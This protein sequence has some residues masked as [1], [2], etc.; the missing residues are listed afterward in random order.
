MIRVGIAGL[1]FM[2]M[3]HYL[4]YQRKRGVR[5]AAICE[6]SARRLAGDWRDI[7]GNFEPAGKRMDLSGVS[8]YKSLPE[9]LADKTL[10]LIDVTLPPALHADVAIQALQ[11]GKHVFCEKPMSLN[12]RDCQR[13]LD[14]AKRAGKLLL[15]GH[16]LPFFPEY[17]WALNVA[18]S[19]KYGRLLGGSFKRVISDPTWLSDYW[20]ADRVGGPMLD[21]HVHDAHFIRLLAGMPK[22]VASCGRLRNE[23]AEF[24][25]T[26]FDYGP[27]GP[28]VQAT[29]GTIGQ[30]SRPFNHGF[31]IHLERA[32]L[33]FEF[34]VLGGE[35][36]YLCPPTVITGSRQ[37][38]SPA[39][40]GGDPLDA[41]AN[42]IGE[43]LHCLRN[44]SHSEILDAQIA[45]D[46][47][48]LCQKQTESLRKGRSVRIH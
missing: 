38:R 22:S 20:Q 32:T 44:G 1:G 13:M 17:R 15:I 24:W 19:G 37:V 14:A 28:V 47:I 33:M 34:A 18:C 26:Q 31:E 46:A 21:L 30:Q 40:A 5:V 9:L 12:P 27:Q 43:V 6:K 41:F 10:D 39:L 4:T 45:Q 7:K 36:H 42:E 16:V 8:T 48:R 35:G 23:L 3:I 11:N 29:S 2:G 25:Y